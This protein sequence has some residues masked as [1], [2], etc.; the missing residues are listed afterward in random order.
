[1]KSICIKTNNPKTIKYLLEKLNDCSLDDVYFSCKKFK[2]YNNII[3]HFKGKNENLFLKNISDILSSLVIELFEQTFIKILVKSEY[4]YFDNF[5]QKQIA[6]NTYDDLYNVEENIYSPKERFNL[7]SDNFY[8]YL[9]SNHSVVLR[10]FINFRIK[11]YLETLLEQIDKSVNKYIVEREYTEFISLLKM[12]I[13]SEVSSC[14][15]VHLIYSSNK[16]ILLDENKVVINTETDMFNAK[17]LSD[18]SFSSNDYALNTLLNLVPK[19]I[20]IHLINSNRDE[21][22]NT[23]S[24]IFENRVIFCNDCSICKAYKKSPAIQS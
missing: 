4:F 8:D 19:K 15:I 23:L 16:P 5:E 21:F 3:I 11:N 13:N 22:I 7:I 12:Y 10:G 17:Y 1:M 2:V 9:I 14:N 6:D 24:L 20:C 18:I